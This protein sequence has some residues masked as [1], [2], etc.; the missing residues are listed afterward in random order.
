MDTSLPWRLTG[1][2]KHECLK[3]LPAANRKDD[4]NQT[5]TANKNNVSPD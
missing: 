3:T 1:K 2:R 4:R 5:K